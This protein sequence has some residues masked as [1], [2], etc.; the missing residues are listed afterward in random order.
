MAKINIEYLDE[1]SAILDLELESHKTFD[2]FFRLLEKVIP[3]DSAT[4]YIYDPHKDRLNV[5]YQTGDYV[6]D[7]AGDFFFERGPGLSSWVSRQKHPV[8]L[9]SIHKS[10]PGKENLYSSFISMPLWMNEALIGV[11]NLGHQEPKV[12]KRIERQDYELVSSRVSMVLDHVLQRQRL[13]EKNH[14]LQEALKDLKESQHSIIEQERMAAINEII[15][16]LNHEINNPLTAILG[17]TEILELTYQTG[18][19]VNVQ[20]GLQAILKEVKRIQRVTRKLTEIKSSE[21]S[22]YVGSSKMTKVPL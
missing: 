1:V 18:K 14:N 16:T 15:V 5:I 8:V 13:E 3:F 6:V 11:L 19:Q 2:A 10:R 9:E 7:L 17:L 21:N 20:R 4:L 22:D 12:Y